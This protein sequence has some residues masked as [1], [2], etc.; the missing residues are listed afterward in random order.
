M[1]CCFP[2]CRVEEK[3]LD[4]LWW[5]EV[6]ASPLFW[7]E[8]RC[9]CECP[10]VCCSWVRG[11]LQL[12]YLF[13]EQGS[14]HNKGEISLSAH[15]FYWTDGVNTDNSGGQGLSPPTSDMENASGNEQES[16]GTQP[17][18]QSWWALFGASIIKKNNIYLIG[19]TFPKF[20]L[21]FFFFFLFQENHCRV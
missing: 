5:R 15:L 14:E 8:G 11:V 12:P 7:V 18:T 2:S 13:M 3:Y 21:R 20:C 1:E 10:S 16:P 17:L 9:T 4:L 6:L 19:F